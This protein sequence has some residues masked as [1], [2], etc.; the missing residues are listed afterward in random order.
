M[1]V[2]VVQVVHMTIVLDGYM[3]TAGRVLVVVL[4]VCVVRRHGL[5]RIS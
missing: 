5:P 4:L 3:A 1:E 2:A